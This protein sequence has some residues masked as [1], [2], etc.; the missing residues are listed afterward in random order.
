MAR[1]LGLELRAEDAIFPVVD[2]T[3]AIAI[4]SFIFY[5][6]A[7]FPDWRDSIIAGTL[8]AT[9]LLRLELKDDQVVHTE[10]LL[11]DIARF[12]DIELGPDGTLYLLLENKSGSQVVRLVPAD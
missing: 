11:E 6:A 8:R 10:V 4:S 9:D 2:W 12:R 3:P 7:P 5:D 1:Q